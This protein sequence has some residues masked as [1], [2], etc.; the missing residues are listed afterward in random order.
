MA[1]EGKVTKGCRVRVL[2]KG[3]PLFV[4][5][6]DLYQGGCQSGMLL[7]TTQNLGG[8]FWQIWVTGQTG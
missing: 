3:E 6:M 5:V 2:R 8:R 1:T 7:I 4:G